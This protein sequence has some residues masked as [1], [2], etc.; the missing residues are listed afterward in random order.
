MAGAKVR[1]CNF[2]WFRPE[3]HINRG[4]RFLS[5]AQNFVEP[6]SELVIWFFL[7]LLS[8]HTLNRNHERADKC[9]N[10]IR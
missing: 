4:Q 10:I 8:G 6:F 9:L 3:A 1:V 7:S 5:K 2:K